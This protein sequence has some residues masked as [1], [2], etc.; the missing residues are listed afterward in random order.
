MTRFRSLA[1]ALTILTAATL[2]ACGKSDDTQRTASA[3]VGTAPA[4]AS[5]LSQVNALPFTIEAANLSNLF[6]DNLKV[7]QVQVGVTGGSESEWAATAIA[8]AERVAT[9][10][11][12][13]IDVSVR[14]NEI[15]QSQGARFREVARVYFSPDPAHTVWKGDP[16]WSIK[17]ADAAHLSTQRDV[18]ITDAY[19]AENRW[20]LDKGLDDDDADRKA[21]AIV[22]KK[23]Q[24]PK[25]W[26][27]PIGNTLREISKESIVVVPEP[28]SE[29]L[30]K[31]TRC[32]KGKIVAG[33][34]ACTNS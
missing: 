26:Q 13:S 16:Q 27:L 10:G 17:V 8:I 20:S 4:A 34:T 5:A 15:T 22:A 32:L 9:F 18:E 2:S 25:D 11:A 31:L 7:S 1:C 29:G 6:R 19:N 33:M 14:R 30:A 28:A 24:L 12:N 3:A 21:G 23:F